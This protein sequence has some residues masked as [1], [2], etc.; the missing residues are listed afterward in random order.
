VDPSVETG[1]RKRKEVNYSQDLMSDREWLR[2][3]DEEFIEGDEEEPEEPQPKRKRRS[4]KEKSSRRDR[5]QP[6]Q[7]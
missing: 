5:E 1:R 3:I 6:E 7:D 2:T 4:H